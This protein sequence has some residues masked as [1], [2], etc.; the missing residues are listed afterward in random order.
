MISAKTLGGLTARAATLEERLTHDFIP[1]EIDQQPLVEAR[2]RRWAQLGAKN[3]RDRLRQSLRWR[4]IELDGVLSALQ[5][6]TL[7]AR[8]GPAAW[9]HDFAALL[10]AALAEHV[11]AQKSSLKDHRG[12]VMGSFALAAKT[13]VCSALTARARGIVTQDALTAMERGLLIRLKR[14]SGPVLDRDFDLFARVDSRSGG[15]PETRASRFAD[16]ML[17]SPLP[18]FFSEYPVLARLVTLACTHWTAASLEMLE[19]LATDY[20]TVTDFFCGGRDPGP[21]VDVQVGDADVHDGHREVLILTFSD[22]ARV[23]YKPRS[24]ALDLAFNKLLAWLQQRGLSPI[25]RSPRV[26]CREGYGWAEFIAHRLAAD[27]A[28]RDA[29]YRRMGVVACIAYLMGSADLHNG[30]VIAQG[31]DPIVIDLE[32]MLQAN[33]RGYP[34]PVL[35]SS[36]QGGS[37]DA[38]PSVLQSMLLPLLHRVPSGEFMD[39][40]AMTA[41]PADLGAGHTIAHWLPVEPESLQQTIH[42]HARTLQEGFTVAY[43]LIL[44]HREALLGSDGP[45]T[46][47][48][49]CPI[50]V[51]LRDT[52]I[53]FQLLRQSIDPACLRDAAD[54]EILLERLNHSIAI[55]ETPP[56]FVEMI[57]REK[58]ALLNLDVPRF[59]VMTDSTD[60]RDFAG[61]VAVNVM[62]RTPLDEMRLRVTNMGEADLAIQ[63]ETIGYSLCAYSVRR[64]RRQETRRVV[65][66]PASRAMLVAAAERIGR[67][68]LR[69][70]RVSSATP[71]R[72][73]GPIFVSRARRFTVG[74]AGAGFADGGMGVALFLAAL[75]RVT[76]NTQWRD[77]AIDLSFAHLRPTAG[78]VSYHGHIP[79][80]L[81]AGIGGLLYAAAHIAAILG[82]D[83]ISHQAIAVV[84]AL[85]PRAI[86]EER[87]MSLSDGLAGT[88]LGIAAIRHRHANATLA[89]ALEQGVASLRSARPQTTNGILCGRAG[90]L[91]AAHRVGATLSCGA[92]LEGSADWAEGSLGQAVAAWSIDPLS[93]QA[94][95]FFAQMGS[96]RNEFL[97]PCDDSF[98]FGLSGEADA[99]AWAADQADEPAWRDRAL[100]IIVPGAERAYR[101]QCKLLGGRLG[102][103]LRMPGLMHGTAGIGYIMLRLVASD[104]LPSLAAL[105]LPSTRKTV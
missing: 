69:E 9:A 21:L 71:P 86:Q 64:V 102:E 37:Q 30:N 20:A 32:T 15:L 80:G 38:A 53:Y 89:Q 1:T 77:A 52:A 85:A 57:S 101:G 55:A 66:P 7:S 3:D 59:L 4:G 24:L 58:G 49:D 8:S 46:A 94:Q 68:L 90:V 93:P 41:A 104:T 92:S 39:L 88:L 40:S 45:L 14:L 29:F 34:L 27:A 22:G 83:E 48:A 97:E 28:E 96:A 100:R 25:M 47:F 78:T 82:S 72:W 73:L 43:R 50:R 62:L 23:V 12:A 70:T 75:F 16:R 11:R 31:G 103:G 105:E 67:D 33:P 76:G 84:E 51:V 99:L 44:Q 19:R 56:G 79:G 13:A 81:N 6:V 91:L 18:T 26:L 65:G 5:N 98:A 54:R 17:E 10:E 2:V 87:D 36:A 42:D 95:G 74:E 60:L 63:Q 35:N 61:V